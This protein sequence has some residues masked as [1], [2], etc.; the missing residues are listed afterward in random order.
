ML[1]S[2]PLLFRFD[3]AS[4]YRHGPGASLELL[5]LLQPQALAVTL[6]VGALFAGLLAYRRGGRHPGVAVARPVLAMSLA[7]G[8]LALVMM[9]WAVPVANQAFR[10][11]A[12]RRP[13]SAALALP[14][15]GAAEMTLAELLDA[16]HRSAGDPRAQATYDFFRHQKAALPAAALVFAL[17]AISLGRERVTRWPVLR[18]AL[19]TTLLTAAY[20]LLFWG[21]R[22]LALGEAIPPWAGAWASNM[23][24]ALAACLAASWRLGRLTTEPPPR[25][26]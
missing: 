11:R 25:N 4:P 1:G 6:P 2:A 7:A 18:A 20:Y 13:F 10:E 5:A 24:F 16:R 8:L 15:K 14:P 12:F 26:R 23:V 21:A 3:G 17:L 9:L 19:L 22:E